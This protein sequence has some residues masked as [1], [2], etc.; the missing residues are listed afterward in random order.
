[1]PEP[2]RVRDFMTTRIATVKPDVK[3]ATIAEAF[4]A[5]PF[6]HLPVVAQDGKLVGIVSD[7][8]LIRACTR[9]RFDAEAP[10]SSIM[11]QVI[12]SISP[13]ATLTEAAERLL[14]L[15]VNSLVVLDDNKRLR[16]ILTARDLVKAIAAQGASEASS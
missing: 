10:A 9:G 16:A 2:R 11:T 3:L 6:H 7:R 4:E 5:H 13:E 8:D 12:A 1:M 14:K 15:G